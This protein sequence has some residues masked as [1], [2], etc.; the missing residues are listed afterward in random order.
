[1]GNQYQQTRSVNIIYLCAA[2]HVH[3]YV[4][5]IMWIAFSES[6]KS[7]NLHFDLCTG[8]DS[9]ILIQNGRFHGVATRSRRS[10]WRAICIDWV[11]LNLFDC[12]LFHLNHN[13]YA[14]LWFNSAFLGIDL[15]HFPPLQRC[16]C[17]CLCCL[18]NVYLFV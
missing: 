3:I 18:T 1:M 4:C 14:K 15:F 10:N 16:V 5:Y 17:V 8:L 2:P 12:V 13:L 11:A 7:R 9:K 6:C